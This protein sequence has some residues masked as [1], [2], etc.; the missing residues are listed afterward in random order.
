VSAR[1]TREQLLRAGIAV[2]GSDPDGLIGIDLDTLAREGARRLLMAA[3]LA[4]V[5]VYVQAASGDRDDSGHALVIRNGHARER[6]ITTA[7]GAVAVTA[8]RVND[9]R[10]DEATGERVR[11]RSVV[12]PPYARRSPKVAEVLPLLYLHGLSTKDF[13][14]ALA[15]FFGSQAGLSA[16]VV[17]RLTASWEAEVRAFAERDLSAS[18]YVYCWADG[19][20]VKVRLGD[21]R[22]L[23]LLVVV[24]VRLDGTKE[25]VALADGYRESKESWADL[26]RDCRRRGLAAPVLAVGDGAIGF[27][28]ALREV[29][30]PTREQRDWVHKSANVL[31]ALPA[32]VHR[33]APG[34]H[35]RDHR[36]GEPGLGGASRGPVRRRVRCQVAE[37]GSED[38]RRPRGAARLLRLPGPALGAS[39]DV[40]PHRVELRPGARPEQPHE[41]AR[42]EGG[43]A[44]HRVQA[45]PGGGAQVAPGERP[46]AGGARCRRSEVRQR[47]AGGGV[48]REGSRVIVSFP[49][50]NI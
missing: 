9:R 45:D 2:P 41:G 20:H 1:I 39:A 49:N 32:S 31:N 19:I 16:S 22:K 7:A 46:R 10:V 44:G 15:L 35:R 4:E 5:E 17:S 38:H 25:L 47:K 6:Q 29:F 18:R 28:A 21:D 13:V 33:R 43:G 27:W 40:E 34:R 37:G 36:C 3:L 11:F 8:P 30:P 14:P 24:G 12:L 23:C 50:H 48:A 26:L 42:L